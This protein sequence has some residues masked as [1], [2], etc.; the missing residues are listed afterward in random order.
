MTNSLIQLI[1]RYQCRYRNIYGN[2]TYIIDEE[3]SERYRDKLYPFAEYWIELMN[4]TNLYIQMFNELAEDGAK[5]QK[6]TFD[7]MNYTQNVYRSL[8]SEYETVCDIEDQF[9][10]NLVS[11]L[12]DVTRI[13]NFVYKISP[14]TGFNMLK[15]DSVSSVGFLNSLETGRQKRNLAFYSDLM[16]EEDGRADLKMLQKYVDYLKENGKYSNI[17]DDFGGL[18]A[19]SV[20]GMGKY[21]LALKEQGIDRIDAAEI[22]L[23][24][25]I[26]DSL[27]LETLNRAG[28]GYCGYLSKPENF[29]TAVENKPESITGRIPGIMKEFYLDIYEKY[30]EMAA[31][32][33]YEKAGLKIREDD[34][35]LSPSDVRTALR[36]HGFASKP[37]NSFEDDTGLQPGDLIISGY[38][39]DRDSTVIEVYVGDGRTVRPTDNPENLEEYLK[40]YNDRYGTHYDKDYM[41]DPDGYYVVSEDLAAG[42]VSVADITNSDTK[43][44]APSDYDWRFVYRYTAGVPM[45]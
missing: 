39:N 24:K 4:T 27:W 12:H 18:S 11:Y 25:A 16:F 30:D 10:D 19:D 29:V 37:L 23:D 13:V 34:V 33:A 42:R 1:R 32:D 3:S 17:V 22:A 9:R 21:Y 20:Q 45:S 41:Y 40:E 8:T 2:K 28:E 5:L 7:P 14:N 35:D 44:I 36:H 38:E 26:E 31:V 15:A 6:F 43:V